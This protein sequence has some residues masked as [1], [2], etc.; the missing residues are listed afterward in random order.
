MLDKTADSSYQSGGENNVDTALVVN[1]SSCSGTTGKNW[2][3][4]YAQIKNILGESPKVA[5]T[6]KSGDGTILTREFLK[7]GFKNIVAIGGDGLINEVANGFF[8]CTVKKERVKDRKDNDITV[9]N[10]DG[11]TKVHEV[12]IQHI[13]EPV[14]P[15]AF[16][17][18]VPCGTRNVLA[19]SLDLPSQLEDCCQRFVNGNPV[20][21]DVISTAVTRYSEK[22]EIDSNIVRELDSPRIF[23]NAAEI[24]VGAEIIDRSKKIRD[25]VKSR[26]LST[27]TSMIATIP[28]YSSNVC[29]LSVDEGRKKLITKMTMA[30]IANGRFLGGGFTAA[31]KAHISDGLLDIVILKNSGSLK[32]L[33][34]FV[35][36]RGEDDNS[37]NDSNEYTDDDNI[38]YTR[39]KKVF[40]KSVEQEKKDV[41]VA[42]DGEPI[43]ILPAAFQVH[44]NALNLK[45]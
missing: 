23:L 12:E 22:D 24:G 6:K 28:T 36:M 32:M 3:T 34:E 11:A 10:H 45:M 15:E 39:A 29:E 7:N 16:M 30:V 38:I 31:T 27:I 33:D 26:I 41:T 25:T 20:K 5:F 4:L 40:M 18:V 14:N 21:I 43:G 8:T 9:S 35:K 1:P 19:R 13:L 42:I 44:S 37:N 17:A 2:D